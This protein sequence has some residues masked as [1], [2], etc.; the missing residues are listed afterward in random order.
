MLGAILVPD[1]CASSAVFWFQ[2]VEHAVSE[3]SSPMQDSSA[4]ALRSVSWRRM[5]DVLVVM[6]VS[7][8]IGWCGLFTWC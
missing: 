3:T 2:G 8:S 1:V 5:D 4:A 6:V 7:P